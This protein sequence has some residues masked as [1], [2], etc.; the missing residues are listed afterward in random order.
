MIKNHQDPSLARMR[1]G[2]LLRD[3]GQI[4]TVADVA[5]TLEM[6]NPEASKLL[7][8]W[9]AQGWVARVKRGLYVAIPLD[10]TSGASALSDPFT[11]LPSLFKRYYVGGWSALEHWDFTD[12]I[13]NSI[14]VVTTDPLRQY[15]MTYLNVKFQAKSIIE[16]MFFGTK[17]IWRDNKKLVISDP[18]KTMID[19]LSYPWLGAGVQHVKECLD[20][21]LNSEHFDAD[22]LIEY[23][24]RQGIN[25]VF[26][27]LGYLVSIS[28]YKS[29]K[30]EDAC[31]SRLTKDYIALDPQIDCDSLVTKWRL[32]VP[33]NWKEKSP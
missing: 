16:H 28:S 12:Q 17:S 4:M 27:R 1:I 5:K 18:H 10:A 6:S 29:Q 33:K 25:A 15:E 7:S 14:L 24:E 32:W 2:K 23:A 3:I 26:K 21:Y 8:K 19:I 13:F 22:T 11:L 30:L 31:F 9:C 20:A